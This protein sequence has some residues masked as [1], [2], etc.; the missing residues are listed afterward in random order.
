MPIDPDT[1]AAIAFDYAKGMT[2]IRGRRVQRLIRREFAGAD[3]VS[4]LELAQG[5]TAVLG[6]SPS[7]A[8]FCATDGRGRQAS[9][10]KWRRGASEALDCR[11]D[12]LKDS[13]PLVES[14]PV[15]VSALDSKVLA[16]FGRSVV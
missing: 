14:A 1:L 5:G 4:V 3:E 9:V 10:V 16:E 13:L 6:R 15:A 11:F 12:L 2:S 8:A 7:G